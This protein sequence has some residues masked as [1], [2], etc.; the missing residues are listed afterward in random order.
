MSVSK[1][2][3]P[4]RKTANELKA[5]ML[6]RIG[7]ISGIHVYHNFV[8]GM[9]YI[10]ETY[11]SL[12]ASDVT[13]SEDQWQG[14]VMLTIKVGPSAFTPTNGWQWEPKIEI[15]DWIVSRASDGTGRTINKQLCR[16]IRDTVITEKIDHPENLR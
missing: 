10:Q 15:G 1:L 4:K 8:L 13:K 6:A 16:L 2:I 12:V 14:K 3:L 7:D 5:E 11:G 9:I